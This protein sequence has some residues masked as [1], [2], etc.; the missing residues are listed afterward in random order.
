MYYL[1]QLSDLNDYKIVMTYD[2]GCG[3][4]NGYDMTVIFYKNGEQVIKIMGYE[5]LSTLLYF[6]NKYNDRNGTSYKLTLDDKKINNRPLIFV[7]QVKQYI[8]KYKYNYM[9]EY[10]LMYSDIF[11]NSFKIEIKDKIIN[12]LIKIGNGEMSIDEFNPFNES[13]KVWK[14]VA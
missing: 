2:I 3:E 5:L 10:D 4:N 13:R 8:E 12:D 6:I 11:K 9:S 14:L 1:K 7:S